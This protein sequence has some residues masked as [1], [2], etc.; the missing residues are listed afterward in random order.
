MAEEKLNIYQ[1]LAKIRMMVEVV[2]KNKSG[3]NYKYVTD[4]ELLSKITAGMK[5][6]QVSLI[7]KI[8]HGTTEVKPYSYEKNK[9]LKNGNTITEIVHEILVEADME[10]QWI[11][12]ENPDER[13][14]VPWTLVGQ[15]N[16]ASQALGSG[17][18]YTYRYFLLKYFGVSTPED[19]PDNWRAKQKEAEML[20]DKLITESIIEE[21]DSFV[22]SCVESKS[23]DD[24]EKSKI[25][26]K[27]TEFIK[28]RITV[29]GK[30]SA[31]Y[32]KI[33]DSETAKKLLTDLK[34]EFSNNRE[35]KEKI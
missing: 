5:K 22:K 35:I 12:D 25:Q 1:K 3:F 2:K 4:T 10:F 26:K 28:E 11:N 32:N 29:N 7:P 19:D 18:T 34:N 31:N 16:D 24:D 8:I 17:L 23:K 14:V 30:K 9:N 27:I 21:I 15:Q 33:I 13:V 6:Y 20:E